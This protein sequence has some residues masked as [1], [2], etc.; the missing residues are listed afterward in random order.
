[1]NYIIGM[2]KKNKLWVTILADLGYN[3][4]IIEQRIT[5][6]SGHVVKPDVI[7]VSN[8]LLHSFVFECKGGRML[9]VNQLERYSSLT[10]ENL[11]RWITVFDRSNLQFDI[12]II[13]LEENHRFIKMVN[14]LFPMLTFS[15]EDL[16]RTR[17]FKRAKL[18]EVFRNPISL[19]GKMP[20]LSYYPFS[21]EDSNSYIA[22]HVI[23]TLLS[24][25]MKNAKGGPDVFERSIISFD[26]I[27]AERFHRVWSALSQRHK[28]RLK[29]KI[30][31]VLRRIM[32]REDM[33][34]SLGI[35]QQKR[36]YRITRNLEQFKKA[37]ENFLAELQSQRPL[38]EFV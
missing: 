13:D 4:E 33:K 24:I 31:E 22:L 8:R 29:D 37:T 34:Q 7:A 9:D 28:E 12:C 5:T 36:G 17:D 21:E 15:T 25:A 3:A 6:S 2:C 35:I 23:R 14:K 1:M 27:V 32:A 19:K 30:C 10:V 11:L 26:E 38:S 16:S 20:P 18:N